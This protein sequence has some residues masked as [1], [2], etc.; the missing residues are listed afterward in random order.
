MRKF[1]M[2]L[3]KVWVKPTWGGTSVCK[4]D[5]EKTTCLL[6]L[7]ER[8]QVLSGSL[9]SHDLVEALLR[10]KSTDLRKAHA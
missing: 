9:I 10:R 7:N 2:R 6:W 5:A 1:L 4:L 3:W 8:E